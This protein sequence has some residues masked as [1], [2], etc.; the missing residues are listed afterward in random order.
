MV[1][2]CLPGSAAERA[3]G[4]AF[5]VAPAGYSPG[6]DPIGNRQPFSHRPLPFGTPKDPLLDRGP[7][8]LD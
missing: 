8:G 6:R 4:K 5:A 7:L 3:L 2:L 1:P